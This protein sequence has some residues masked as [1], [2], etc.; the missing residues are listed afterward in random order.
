MNT[1]SDFII[2]PSILSA[3]FSILKEEIHRL[4]Q[5]GADWIHVDVMDGHFVPNLTIG[6]PVVKSLRPITKL[7]LD[8]HLM[9]EKPERYI[10]DF[11]EAGADF[12][13][14]HI[15]STTRV[16]EVLKSIRSQGCRAGITLKP[17]TPVEQIFDFLPLVDL[18]LIMTVNPGFGGQ[19]FMSDQ[20]VKIDCVRKELQRQKLSALIEVDGG[21]NSETAYLCSEADVLVAGSHIFNKN[22]AEAIAELKGA[23]S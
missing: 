6:A 2:A 21:I 5:A 10:D 11:I 8:V 16:A 17:A 23:R 12:L 22:Y 4:E 7:P 1:H 19:K 13:T 18:I 20:V 3:D 9:I 14:V 15:E